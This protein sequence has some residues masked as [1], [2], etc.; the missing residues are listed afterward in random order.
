[1]WLYCKRGQIWKEKFPIST[2]S[3][4]G[5]RI[6]SSKNKTHSANVNLYLFSNFQL[7]FCLCRGACNFYFHWV[8]ANII[9]KIAFAL[10]YLYRFIAITILSNIRN[11]YCTNRRVG[12]VCKYMYIFCAM[13][14][15]FSISV[16]V[17]FYVHLSERKKEMG[18]RSVWII[19]AFK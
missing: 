19:M 18:I 11:S 2:Y 1:M 16:C 8:N 5:Y 6:S 12:L 9:A 4:T 7:T 13:C 14:I 3:C 17:F 10:D 15:R